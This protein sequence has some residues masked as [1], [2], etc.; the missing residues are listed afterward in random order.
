M[1]SIAYLADEN[2][3]QYHRMHGN[4]NINFWRVG[5]RNFEN[6]EPG[7]LL[8]FIDGK[9]RHPKT[10]EKGIVGY[11]FFKQIREMSIKRTW[12]QYREEN[13]YKSYERF[14]EAVSHMAKS[15]D[16]PEKIQSIELNNVVY[17]NQAM[18]LGEFTNSININLE[19]FIYLESEEVYKLLE[20][21]YDFGIDT[22]FKL[23]NPSLDREQIK[24]DIE[25]AHLRSVLENIKTDWTQDQTRLI[26]QYSAFNKVGNIAY[27]VK[28]HEV[29]IFIPVSSAKTQYYTVLGII[30]KIKTE[31]QKNTQFTLVVRDNARPFEEEFTKFGLKLLYT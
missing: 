17:F 12:Q 11:G 6:F 3:L 29:E 26:N 21:G 14:E 25:I 4:R 16:L 22:W 7:D 24:K 8:F 28:D 20:K 1:S 30:Y 10:R 31:I 27:L 19:S 2:M 13:G 18:Y 5:I 9:Q 23:N 15:D